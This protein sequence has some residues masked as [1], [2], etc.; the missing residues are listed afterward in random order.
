[1]G[2]IRSTLMMPIFS[3]TTTSLPRRAREIITTK[4]R[5]EAECHAPVSV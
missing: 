5:G 1:M 3:M 2:I 4:A